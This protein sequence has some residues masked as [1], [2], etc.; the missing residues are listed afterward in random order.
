M[1]NNNCI[2]FA[3]SFW[4][5]STESGLS[6]GFRKLG[7]C[8]QEV[9]G[10][11]LGAIGQR[12]KG[13]RIASRLTRKY[14]R[15]VYES[16]IV[17]ACNILKPK[18]FIT[19]KGSE[20]TKGLLKRVKATGAQTVMYYPDFHFDYPD[21]SADSFD[22]YDFFI[23]TKTHQ[24]DHL[25]ERLTKPKSVYYL[26][27]GYCSAV[28]R[29]LY[30][31]VSESD[32]QADVLHAGSHSVYKQAWIESAIRELP[33]VSFRLIGPRWSQN[34]KNGLLTRS[35]MPGARTGVAYAEAIQTSRINVAVH[36][37]P[38]VQGWEDRVSTR[39]F[40]IPACGGFMLHIDS[41]EVRDIYKVGTEID[42]FS[43]P[44][45]L[46]DKIRFYLRNPAT[47]ERMIERAF[48][49]CVPD[50]SYDMRAEQIMEWV[51]TGA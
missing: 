19:V 30:K 48:A 42:V 36:M 9:D 32:F 15:T 44:Q 33:E 7:W 3:G 22:E 41:E 28:H 25:R 18:F 8:V 10:R 43:S 34:A 39:T 27:H 21:V 16:E 20:I 1:N 50:Y 13:F 12:I 17:K 6:D 5:G 23:T 2:V 46:A 11:D 38:T 40:E 35:E 14:S 31:S 4:T 24:L 51:N 47:R 29:P 45:E 37:G 26:P 49:R